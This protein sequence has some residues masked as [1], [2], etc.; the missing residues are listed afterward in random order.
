MV[1]HDGSGSNFKDYFEIV[2]QEMEMFRKN[3]DQRSIER[4]IGSLNEARGPLVFIGIGA[5]EINAKRAHHLCNTIGK[6]SIAPTVSNLLHGG[7]GGLA[8]SDS[9]VIFSKSGLTDEI[10]RLITLIGT[11]KYRLFLVTENEKLQEPEVNLYHQ[12]LVLG[13]SIEADINRVLPT[14]S[15]LKVNMFIDLLARGLQY[16]LDSNIN[17]ETNHPGGMLGRFSNLTLIE[18]LDDKWKLRHLGEDSSL[19]E[20]LE[21]I[22]IFGIGGISI[23]AKDFSLIGIISD[24]DVRRTLVNEKLDLSS[25]EV[26]K[27]CHRLP[28]VLRGDM[29]IE[30]SI[31]LINQNKH[32]SF[33]PV[34]R[35][36]GSFIA[37]VSSR[38]ILTLS[39]SGI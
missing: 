19:S 14:S 3:L 34:I 17:L 31:K 1:R 35:Q 39:L 6:P 4:L 27:I 29:T 23:T 13:P 30:E 21:S 2:F 10:L 16:E 33:F 28:V 26:Q 25:S 8:F 20:I 11:Q 12:V 18:A 7:L 36:D 9:I 15:N 5:S 22:T 24:G 37:T 38:E 32:L